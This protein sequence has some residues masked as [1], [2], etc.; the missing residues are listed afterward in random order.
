MKSW[1]VVELVNSLPTN[2]AVLRALFGLTSPVERVEP[3]EK[4]G[5]REGPLGLKEMV[6]IP[7]GPILYSKEKTQQTIEKDFLIDVYPVTNDQFAR[8]IQ[9]GGYDQEKFWSQE[10]WKWKQGE[11]VTQPQ[12]WGDSKWN[13]PDH[14]VVGV[15]GYEAEAFAKWAKKWLPTEMEWERAA[16]GTDG[17]AYPWGDKFQ[18]EFCNSAESKFGGTTPVTKYLEGRSPE[19]CY[20]MA[21]NVWEWTVDWF[22]AD[23]DTYVIRGGSWGV[24]AR[25]LR[26]SNRFYRVPTYWSFNIGFRCAQDAR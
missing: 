13:Q 2:V 21:G 16:R 20:D 10:G 8:F 4:R 14:P 25:N 6:K 24:E 1:E 11:G 17:R 26:S 9:E 5:P 7:A 3:V 15:S 19:G 22:D 12:Y 23:K 18:A